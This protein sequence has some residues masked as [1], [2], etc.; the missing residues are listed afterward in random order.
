[1][2]VTSAVRDLQQYRLDANG[3]LFDLAADPAQAHDLSTAKPDVAARLS[4]AVQDWKTELLADFKQDKRPFAV[5]YTEFPVTYLP[6]RDGVAHGGVT[7]SSRAPNCSYFRNWTSTDDSITWNIEV[8]TAGTYEA[9]IYATC[10]KEDVGSAIE[11]SLGESRI[12]GTMAEPHDPPLVGAEHDRVPAPSPNRADEG[13]PAFCALGDFSLASGRGVL[14]APGALKVPRQAGHGRPFCGA[15]FEKMNANENGPL[16]LWSIRSFRKGTA[17]RMK[18]AIVIGASSG[19]GRA[20]G[21]TLAEAG[22]AV[23]L[24]ARRVP[25]LDELKQEIGGSTIVKKIDVADADHAM[26]SLSELLEEMGQVDL[27]VI[28]AGV[29]FINRELEWNPE[30]ETIAV[31][32][33]GFAAMANVSAEFV[34]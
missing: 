21:K 2:A 9:V 23:G 6:A 19:I 1:M 4:Q 8:A 25:L 13:L 7:R 3:K 18:K 14:D 11:L 12:G 28:C 31:N 16:S 24:A 34:S 26:S 29:G 27:V 33:T 17:L 20:L 22:Y 10:P 5:G 15:Y 30:R 32:V